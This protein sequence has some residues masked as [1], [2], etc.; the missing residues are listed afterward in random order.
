[1]PRVERLKENLVEP[2]SPL[3]GESVN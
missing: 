3:T 1:V 2:Y